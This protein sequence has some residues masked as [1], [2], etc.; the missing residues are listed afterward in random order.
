MGELLI[1]A[2]YSDHQVIGD[3]LAPGG[4]VALR[5][6]IDGLVADAQTAVVRPTL[7]EAAHLAGVPYV[8]D[9]LTPLLQS[10][11]DPKDSWVKRVSFGDAAGLAAGDFDAA[12]IDELA[13]AVVEFEV[14]SK[15]TAIVAPYLYVADPVDPAFTVSLQLLIATRRYM[16]RND[17]NLPLIAVFCGGWQRFARPDTWGTGVDRFLANAIDVDPQ[18]LALCLTPAGAAKDAYAKVARIFTT[19]RR[20]AASGV[21]TIVW[22]QGIFGPGLVGRRTPRLRDRCRHP[23]EGRRARLDDPQEA[24]DQPQRIVRRA[25]PEDG[26]PRGPGP[27]CHDRRGPCS[28]GRSGYSRPAHLRQRDLLPPRRRFDARSPHPAHHQRPRGADA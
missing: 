26:L 21:P 14:K 2:G 27:Q 15:A 4:A 25:A 20:F 6:P 10:P 17:V 18:S 16:R 28:A 1:R 19:A 9:P 23:G 5:P 12:R 24:Q 22:R 8:I 11:T 13:S 7:A 3:L